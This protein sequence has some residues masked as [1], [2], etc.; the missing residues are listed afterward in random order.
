MNKDLHFWD[1]V[2]YY[3]LRKYYTELILGIPT[4][5]VAAMFLV[6]F[7]GPLYWRFRWTFFFTGLAFLYIL[8]DRVLLDR[9]A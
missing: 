7:F 9:L 2:L 6:N 8:C 3:I 5:V 1:L 4:L